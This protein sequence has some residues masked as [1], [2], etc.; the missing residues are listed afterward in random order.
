MSTEKIVSIDQLAQRSAELKAQGKTVALCHGTFDL[1]H[2][3][4]IRHLQSG[5]RQADSL[6]VSVT[7]DEFVNKGPG[8]PV[9]NEHLRA[10]NIAALACVDRVAINHAVTAVEVLDQVK[11]DLYVKGSDYKSTS[12][13]ITGNIQH[14]KDAVERHG[15]RILFTD[16]LTSSST[17]LLNEYF[18]VFSPEISAYLDQFKGTVG[19]ADIIGKLKGL[20]GLKVL[21]VGEAI[22]DEYHY[23][24]PLGQTGKGN[25]FAVKYNDYERFA[26]GAI[27]VANHVAEFAGNVTLLTGLG[28]T[29][30]HE[31]F[32]RSNLNPAIEPVFFFSQDRPTIVKRRYVDADIA[33]LFEVYFYNDAPLPEETNGKIVAWLDRHLGDYDAVIVPDFGNGFISNEMVEALAKGAKYLAVNAQV[34]SGN[35]GYHLITRY[36][37]ADFL[38]LNEPEL[39]LAVHDRNGA[40]EELAGQLADKLQAKHVAITRGTKGALMLDNDKTAYKIPALSSQ[41]VDRIGAGD[42]FLSVAGLCLAGGLEPEQALFAGSVAAALDVQIVCNREPVRAVALFKYITTLLK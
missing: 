28:A 30:S 17:R 32:I 33:K 39:R 37:N 40:I 8:R 5:S 9:F 23:T 18:E 36:P 7:A 38:S 3:G 16:E 1:L 35:R 21:V 25:V 13:D 34:N 2:I 19:G 27:A 10:E 15:G 42:A 26:G 29:Q 20:S 24:S 31:D 14:E 22:I 6:L 11:P 12:D 41:V 4:H